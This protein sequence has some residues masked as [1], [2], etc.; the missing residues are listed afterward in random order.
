MHVVCLSENS[1]YPLSILKSA[2]GRAPIEFFFIS[3]ICLQRAGVLTVLDKESL[4]ARY[5]IIFYSVC[6]LSSS[7]CT[8]TAEN[9]NSQCMISSD[10]ALLLPWIPEV[11]LLA[12]GEERQSE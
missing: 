9:E 3:H 12:T 8:I 6:Y 5:V 7:H 2:F 4:F 10:F 1:K 11:F